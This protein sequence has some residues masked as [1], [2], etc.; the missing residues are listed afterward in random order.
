MRLITRND[1]SL[2]VSLIAATIILFQQPL[3]SLIEFTQEVEARYHVDLIPALMLLVVVFMFHVY[4]KRAEAK[5]DARSAA[6]EAV[7]ARARSEELVQLMAFGQAL[8]NALDRAALQQAVSKHLSTFTRGREFWLLIRKGDRWE[9]LLQED[10]A[11]GPF[12]A[13]EQAAIR[14]ISPDST[15]GADAHPQDD[16]FPLISAGFPVGV[17]G[18]RNGTPLTAE[19]RKVISAAAALIAI[20]VRNMQLFLETREMSL[21]D[22]LTGCFNR[23]HAV[24]T[25]DAE[26]R[27][28]RRNTRPL[29]IVMFDVD[30]FKSINDGLGHLRGDQVLQ[31][32]G[33]Q[34]NRIVRSTDVRCRFGG[35]EFLV[36]LPDTPALGAEQVAECVRREMA[37]LTVGEGEHSTAVTVSVGVA[38][39][40]SGDRTA[41][42]L[43][44]RADAALYEAKRG[45]R[46]RYSVAPA[47]AAAMLSLVKADGLAA[48]YARSPGAAGWARSPQNG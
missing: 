20:G 28:S 19:E 17:I 47:S 31:A 35:D 36:I 15:G 27:R 6:A 26:L 29:S 25:L 40:L 34:L 10:L 4:R 5:A 12:D 3:R 1:T 39:A 9:P 14:A 21:R 8:A 11:S 41:A 18:V 24:E 2:A 37:T 30:R 33:A 22:G 43:I 38:T 45:G 23:A 48:M 32:V 46:N 44:E 7:Q 13:M 16:C 42:A